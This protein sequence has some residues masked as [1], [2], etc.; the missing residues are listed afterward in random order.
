MNRYEQEFYNDIKRIAVAL[1]KLVRVQNS[2]DI[3]DFKNEKKIKN[4][5]RKV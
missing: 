5:N 4:N 2:T 3:I 1:E